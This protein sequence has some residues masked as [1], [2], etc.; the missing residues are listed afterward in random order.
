MESPLDTAPENA[1]PAR[2]ER[3]DATILACLALAKLLL[4]FAVNGRYGY[5]IDELYFIACG[6]HLAWGYVDHP[7][8]IAAV[9]QA[10]R[11]LMGDSL[12]AIRFFPAVA[13]A[14]L[15]FLTGW[16]AR[17][18]G[19]GRFAQVL[20]ATTVIIAPIY[21]AFNNL[22]TM[23]AFEPLLWTACAYV[24]V[25][26]V[27]NEDPRLW[28]IVGL[29]AGIGMLNKHSMAFFG[30][31]VAVGLL[32]TAQRRML[33][34]PWIVAGAVVAFV[35]LLPHLL[36]QVR[37]GW[38]TVELL[39]NAKLYQHQPVSPAEFVWGQ[40]QLM[41]PF[42]LPIWVAGVY[43]YLR[44][45]DSRSYRFLGWAFVLL[46][47]A[48]LVG[49]AKTYYLGPIY[50]T[51]LAAGAVATEGFANRRRWNWLK[52]VTLVLLLIGG[53]MSAPYVL[54]VLPIEAV[55]RYLA[56]LGMKDVR[57]E[58]RAEG[59]IPQLFADM[60]AWPETVAAVARV[61][62]SL[63]PE[64]QARCAIWGRSY[65][66]AAAVDFFGG[67]YGLPR[68]ISG[69]Q[70]YYLW[71]PGNTSGDVMITVS[72][73]GERLARWFDTVELMDTVP[74]EYCMPDRMSTP[75]YVCRGLKMPLREFWP[76]VKCWT[77]DMPEFARTVP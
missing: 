61:Y 30:G 48:A 17:A 28:L 31:S 13:G 75:I 39:R 34:T 19:G 72:I 14:L 41:H 68:A 10:S 36:W 2:D 1:G 5:W 44:A 15:V 64:D 4:H 33:W 71:G 40:I 55:P 32:L 25:L 76:K 70:N 9:A 69:Y 63:S 26:I 66:E 45:R 51:V 21:L 73:P 74:C 65:G 11:A 67:A 56:I 27:K 29:I 50:P 22:L 53:V 6:E 38:P 43:F 58:R 37:L 3:N 16:L 59:V 62:H 52:P 47:A 8:L 60:F 54:P 18:L 20:A 46:F 7:P 24:V 42:T 49:Q 77:C 23:N 35:I 57:P 12:F